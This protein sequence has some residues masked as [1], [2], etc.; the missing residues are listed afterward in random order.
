[1][2][3]NIIKVAFPLTFILSLIIYNGSMAQVLSTYKATSLVNPTLATAT[4]K[5]S[6][7][8]E[9]STAPSVSV[10]LKTYPRKLTISYQIPAVSAL[11]WGKLRY[12]SIDAVDSDLSKYWEKPA[13]VRSAL[14]FLSFA[15]FVK[16]SSYATLYVTFDFRFNSVTP[17]KVQQYRTDPKSPVLTSKTMTI[18]R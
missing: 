1:M 16:A 3:I 17:Y 6:N 11:E 10:D 15:N 5:S 4:T 7:I 18:G 14:D 9:V 8:S 12:R 2:K 13:D